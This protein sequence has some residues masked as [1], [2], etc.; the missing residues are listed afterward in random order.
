M[1]R[2]FKKIWKETLIIAIC[3]I[4]LG[5]FML[6]QPDKTLAF[7]SYLIGALILVLAV[8]AFYRHYRLQRMI[9]FELLYGIICTVGALLIFL[10][11]SIIETLIPIVLGAVMIANSIFKI[12][13]IFDLKRAGIPNWFISL[14]LSFVKIFVGIIMILNPLSSMMALTQFIGFLVLIFAGCD[15]V[16]LCFIRYNLNDELKENDTINV[17][18]KKI[19]DANHKKIDEK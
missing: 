3:F 18:K 11:Q 10:N 13:Y 2:P 1:N 14:I 12:Q 7:F 19:M 16:D 6:M 9:T 8:L 4:L 15:V 17:S 5:C